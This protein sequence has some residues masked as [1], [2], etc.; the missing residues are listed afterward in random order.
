LAQILAPGVGLAWVEFGEE[1]PDR[2]RPALAVRSI[3]P[4]FRIFPD[5]D[6]QGRAWWV[7]RVHESDSQEK[8]A[9]M[10]WN[11]R[12][13]RHLKISGNTNGVMLILNQWLDCVRSRVSVR[14]TP[15][16][17]HRLE[18]VM[19]PGLSRTTGRHRY[20]D[21]LSGQAA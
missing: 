13:F 6:R 18:G 12:T 2:T 21:H 15:W 14:R 16:F 10:T 9:V 11:G 19:I 17:P 8:D 20:P 4:I 7:Y 1:R 3:H 5:H